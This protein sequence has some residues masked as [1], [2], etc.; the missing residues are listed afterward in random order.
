[1]KMNI[2][3]ESVA[4]SVCTLFVSISSQAVS[5]G[6]E[7]SARSIL[8]LLLLTARV[9]ELSSPLIPSLPQSIAQRMHQ[10]STY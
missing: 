4:L 9:Q 10:K 6:E 2:K 1:M 7:T 8:I 3:I 5:F